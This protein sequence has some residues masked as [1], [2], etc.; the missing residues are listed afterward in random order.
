MSEEQGRSMEITVEVPW[1]II[2]DAVESAGIGYWCEAYDTLPVD[3]RTGFVG[4]WWFVETRDE[5]DYGMAR[6]G[7]CGEYKTI[8]PG[9][10]MTDAEDEAARRIVVDEAALR[11]ALVLLATKYPHLWSDLVNE[12][13][14]SSTGDALV[15]LACF[16]ELR[17][18]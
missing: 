17:Y 2:T 11:R 14:D 18:A 6:W 9:E 16:G 3:P 12:T 1:R 15:Q 4:G 13:G 8:E 5:E 7:K 10:S